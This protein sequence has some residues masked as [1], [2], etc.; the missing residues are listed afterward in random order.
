MMEGDR[1]EA[2]E[3]DRK[4]LPQLSVIFLNEVGDE[5]SKKWS[6]L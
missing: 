4:G 5:G 6:I 3:R 2:E 1:P